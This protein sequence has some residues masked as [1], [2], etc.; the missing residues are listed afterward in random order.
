MGTHESIPRRHVPLHGLFRWHV[1]VLAD[2][3]ESG[4]VKCARRIQGNAAVVP[5]IE[6]ILTAQPAIAIDPGIQADLVTGGAKLRCLEK[7]LEHLPLV[8][9]GAR[10]HGQIMHQLADTTV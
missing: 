4:Q 8:D 1:A 10:L 6:L 5:V 3:P 2:T 9:S 7:G